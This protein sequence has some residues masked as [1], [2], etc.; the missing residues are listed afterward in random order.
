M[1]QVIRAL[2]KLGV[3]T[4][5]LRCA[6]FN[7]VDLEAAAAASMKVLRVVRMQSLLECRSFYIEPAYSPNAVA[8]HAIAMVMCLNRKLHRAY[9]RVRDGVLVLDWRCTAHPNRKLQLGWSAGIRRR[10]KDRGS[11]RHWYDHRRYPNGGGAFIRVKIIFH[12]MRMLH[13]GK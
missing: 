11:D 2:S 5:L 10:N 7:N 9:T 8:E 12:W 3:K 1:G 13:L 6:G 4:I